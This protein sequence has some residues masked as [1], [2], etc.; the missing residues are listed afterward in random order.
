MT[1]GQEL[2]QGIQLYNIE[3]GESGEA[4]NAILNKIL[5][6]GWDIHGLKR[7]H[8]ALED[9]FLNLVTKEGV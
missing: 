6:N 1:A 2:D 4:I 9:I 8:M 7:Q 3:T 5:K